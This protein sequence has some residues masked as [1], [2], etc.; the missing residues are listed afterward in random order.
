VGLGGT[1]EGLG[2]EVR[3][4]AGDG[5]TAAVLVGVDAGAWQADAAQSSRRM[6]RWACVM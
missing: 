6:Q 5:C 4:G 1:G 3:E 2:A